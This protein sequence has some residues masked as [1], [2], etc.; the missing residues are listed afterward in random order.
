MET[1]YSQILPATDSDTTGLWQLNLYTGNLFWSDELCNLLKISKLNA[2]TLTQLISYYKLEQN[3][4]AAFNRAI[5]QGIPFELNFPSLTNHQKMIMVCTTGNPVY[6]DYGKCI[7]IRGDF[8]K[9]D[10]ENTDTS[11]STQNSD[12]E[13]FK[14]ENF[15][16]IVSHNLRSHTSNLQMVLSFINPKTTSREIKSAIGDIR[17]IS[18]NLNQTV[19]YLNTLIQI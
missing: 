15:A 16:R 10:Q 1:A 7:A 8:Q 2:P 4:S 6:D 18:G 11:F 19:G 17:T 5:H 3:L 13:H 14:L 9:A 12:N